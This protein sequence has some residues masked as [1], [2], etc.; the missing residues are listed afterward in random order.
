MCDKSN[1][2]CICKTGYSGAR[3]DQC[4]PGYFN[5]PDCQPCN[6][7]TLGS[8]STYC[9][10]TGKCPCLPNFAGKQC[11]QCST[12]NYAYPECL[13][14]FLKVIYAIFSAANFNK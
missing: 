3:C 9:D 6:C 12:G 14:K 10:A 8:V 4:L 5:Y 13:R 2:K 11:T 1:G 7:S